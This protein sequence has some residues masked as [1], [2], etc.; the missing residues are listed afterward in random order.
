LLRPPG[1]HAGEGTTDG[2]NRRTKSMLDLERP[3]DESADDTRRLVAPPR[4]PQED[5]PTTRL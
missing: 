1:E 3:A 4:K 2:N 5:E